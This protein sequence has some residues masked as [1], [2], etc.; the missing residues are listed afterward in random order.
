MPKVNVYLPDDLADAVRETG[1]PVSKV[2]QRALEQAVRDVRSTKIEGV[3]IVPTF[4]RFTN[5]A[6]TVVRLSGDHA[7]REGVDLGSEHVLLGLVEEGEGVGARALAAL[8]VTTEAVSASADKRSS[9]ADGSGVYRQALHEALKLGHNYIGTEHMA[10]GMAEIAN[11]T[12]RDILNELGVTAAAL[13]HQV[14]TILTDIG[15]PAAP[16][17]D[18]A[19]KLDQ[20]VK[21]LEDLEKRLP[22]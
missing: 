21:R 8:G 13:R 2:C 14:I 16:P 19:T 17:A 4:E 7:T 22:A 11:T 6:R 12:A 9:T 10:L 3:A 1:V 18:V 20:I 15:V 5:R